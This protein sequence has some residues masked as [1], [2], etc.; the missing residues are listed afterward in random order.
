MVVTPPTSAA[1][2]GTPSSMASPRELGEFSMVD[3]STN[4]FASRNACFISSPLRLPRNSIL[5]S[6]P[7]CSARSARYFW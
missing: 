4:T 3:G 2:Q 6:T 1:T 7:Y 5:S